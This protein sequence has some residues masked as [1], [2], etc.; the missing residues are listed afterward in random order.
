M[1]LFICKI[2]YLVGTRLNHQE[3]GIHVGTPHKLRNAKCLHTETTST[4]TQHTLDTLTL[5][6][7]GVYPYIMADTWFTIMQLN[8]IT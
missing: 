5:L 4:H 3:K 2:K 7:L 1:V 6:V 8:A